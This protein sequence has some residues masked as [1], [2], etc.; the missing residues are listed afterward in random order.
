MTFTFFLK[1]QYQCLLVVLVLE[2]RAL[3]TVYRSCHSHVT[4]ILSQLIIIPTF[5]GISKAIQ[6][7]FLADAARL[8]E[9]WALH[10][11]LEALKEEK[12]E[13]VEDYGDISWRIDGGFDEQ[14][15]SKT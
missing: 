11:G 5:S 13:T 10:A 14:S 2:V 9:D 6:T 7:I 8:W 15:F 1:P 3:L 12:E 4:Q